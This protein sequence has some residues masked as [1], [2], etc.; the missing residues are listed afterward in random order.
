MPVLRDQARDRTVAKSSIIIEYLQQHYPGGTAL[1]PANPETALRTRLA[2]RF[3]DLYVHDPMQRIE[4]MVITG[5]ALYFVQR[6]AAARSPIRR[7]SGGGL[8][9]AARL[10]RGA[11]GDATRTGRRC[12]WCRA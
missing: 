8:L 11:R 1:I 3:Y 10:R 2:D 7:R 9:A 4:Q 5:I 12:S 6:V